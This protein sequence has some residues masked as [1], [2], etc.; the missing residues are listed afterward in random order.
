[1]GFFLL[2]Y[3]LRINSQEYG[4]LCQMVW[5]FIVHFVSVAKLFS[6]GNIPIYTFI[7]KTWAYQFSAKV[8]INFALSFDHIC[9]WGCFFFSLFLTIQKGWINEHRKHGTSNLV[10]NDWGILLFS[11]N[12]HC[13]VYSMKYYAGINKDKH[14]CCIVTS[15]THS[16]I[17]FK[18][19][20]RLKGFGLSTYVSKPT[21][22]ER[23]L[24]ILSLVLCQR[25]SCNTVCF[26]G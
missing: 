26:Q 20:G 9:A 11:F 24:C 8:D 19:K 15:K 22:S 3:C 14:K 18:G 5:T 10:W 21:P 13:Y 17:Q 2:N 25:L 12:S 23:Q 6:K 7:S 16:G 1:M 4:E